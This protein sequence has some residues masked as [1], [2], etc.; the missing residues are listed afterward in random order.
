MQVKTLVAGVVTAATWYFST[1][2]AQADVVLT[3]EGLADGEPI[4][5]FYAGGTGGFL[6][7]PGP[8]YGI[9]FSSD[10]QALISAAAGGSGQFSNNPSGVTVAFFRGGVGDTM[11]VP[12]GFNTGF[13]FF[14][15]DQVGFTGNVSVYSGLNATGDLLATLSLP[16]TPNPYTVWVPIG[17][18]FAGT[19][20]SVVFSGSANFIGFDDITLGSATPGTVPLPAALPL[21]ATG[22]GVLG[23]LGWHRKRKS[24][25]T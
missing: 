14:Y 1:V 20:E 19:A 3:F 8:N 17:V 25:G 15:A 16:S 4:N 2:A 5:N 24:S 18:S 11:N 13:S 10:S 6:S 12:S 21:F 7:G 9:T 23:L 22:L